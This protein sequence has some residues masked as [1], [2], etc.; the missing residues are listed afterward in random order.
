MKGKRNT[1]A[2]WQEEDSRTFID[3]A[4]YFV[5]ERETQFQIICDLIP[6]RPAPFHIL[7]LCCGQ[8]LLA[9]AILAQFPNATVHGYDGSPEMLRNAREKLAAYGGRFKTQQFDLAAR[10]WRQPAWPIHAVVSSLAIHH[11][12]G[13]GKQALFRDVQQM[14]APGDVLI[15]ADLVQPTTELGRE[16]A[17][18]AWDRVVRQRTQEIDG[19]LDAFEA[20]EQQQW[21]MYRYPESDDVDKPSTL[22]D[23]LQWLAQAGFTDVDVHWMQAGHAIFSGRKP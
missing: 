6:P 12:D 9:A 4:R 1:P 5:P 11:L 17:A 3:Y 15:V 14:L 2:G 13:S 20:F 7:E 22:F 18:R 19:N 16:V 21:N 10:D 23:Q 8:G